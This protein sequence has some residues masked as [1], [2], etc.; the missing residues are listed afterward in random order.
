MFTE[1]DLSEGSKTI[2][3]NSLKPI[4]ASHDTALIRRSFTTSSKQKGR[5]SGHGAGSGAGA[6]TGNGAGGGG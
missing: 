1:F 3:I 2:K 5:G 6:G 4:V